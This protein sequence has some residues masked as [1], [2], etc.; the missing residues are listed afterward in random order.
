MNALKTSLVLL[1]L[2]MCQVALA[3]TG[4][5]D[6]SMQIPSF[7][8]QYG[9]ARTADPVLLIRDF[10]PWG[11][12]IVPF[13]TANGCVVTVIN[14]ADIATVNLCDYCMVVVTAGTTG[15]YDTIYQDNVNAAVPLFEAYLSSCNPGGGVMLY[16]TGTWGG[17][18]QMPGGAYTVLDYDYDNWF[19]VAAGHCSAWLMPFPYFNGNYASHDDLLNL[20]GSAQV[21]TSGTFGQTTSTRYSYGTGVVFALTHPVECYI[22]GGYCYGQAPHFNQFENNIINCARTW[23]QCGDPVVDA[24]DSPVA[25]ELKGNHPNPF[26]PVTAISFSLPETADANLS[27]F[28][29][30]GERV[31]TL[32]NGMTERGEHQVSFNAE[33][34][35]SGLYIYRLEALGQVQ[36][37]RMLLVK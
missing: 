16:Q 2:G 20:P 22:P 4:T 3:D 21:I 1:T 8:G 19:Q 15:Y 30:T 9:D 14:S 33:A 31:A 32:V 7:P 17:S 23:G 6:P 28:S 34:L 24:N 27:V 37:G 10:L 5:P 35:S 13:F 11:G 36:S 29:L 12:D 25:F 18:I 26:N